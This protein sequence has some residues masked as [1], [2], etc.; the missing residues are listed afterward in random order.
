MVGT[1]AN[2]RPADFNDVIQRQCS[3]C[4]GASFVDDLRGHGRQPPVKIVYWRLGYLLRRSSGLLR[5]WNQCKE[6]GF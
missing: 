2:G 3:F 4:R 6:A 1:F 5:W